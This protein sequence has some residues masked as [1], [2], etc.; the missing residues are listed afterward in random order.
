MEVIKVKKN[1]K[2]RLE[3]RITRIIDRK[4]MVDVR[5]HGMEADKSVRV[6]VADILR[7]KIFG[8]GK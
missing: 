2:V 3:G 8:W 1:E 4:G 6:Y 5:I 7:K